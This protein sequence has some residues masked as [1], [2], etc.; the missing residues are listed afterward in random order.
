[1]PTQS[2]ITA[3]RRDWNSQAKIDTMTSGENCDDELLD[4]SA[5]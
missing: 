2:D 5:I 1:M 3:T 4:I